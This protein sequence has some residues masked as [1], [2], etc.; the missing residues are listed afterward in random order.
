MKTLN[1]LV[2][3]TLPG[4]A[5]SYTLA[6]T[7]CEIS[8]SATSDGAM[9]FQFC[10]GGSYCDTEDFEV[11]LPANPDTGAGMTTYI[12]VAPGYEP[13]TARFIKEIGTDGWCISTVTWE[14]GSNL[15]GEDGYFW[16]DTDSCVDGAY[17]TG[18]CKTE[19]KLFNLDGSSDYEYDVRIKA[20]DGTSS[21]AIQA[22]FCSAGVC[23]GTAGEEELVELKM[24]DVEGGWTDAS[25]PLP[26]N[27]VAMRLEE[28]DGNGTWCAEE[29]AFNGFPLAPASKVLSTG[30]Q[31]FW[32]IQ[33]GDQSDGPTPAPVEADDP[34]PSPVNGVTMT[35]DESGQGQNDGPTPSPLDGTAT[36]GEEPGDNKLLGASW[37]VAVAVI[38]SA[39]AGA[40]CVA[41]T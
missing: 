6:V 32:N 16:L 3:A 26:F 21:S 13:T 17:Q 40:A 34:T 31:T 39:V 41:L 20:C 7:T 25:F 15:L 10:L 2:F 9:A 5:R 29:F 18:P 22:Y 19:W 30:A 33:N 11:E 14:G 24:N 27:P 36:N 1:L 8:N 23:D 4:G 38:T 35:D 28:P 37:E 12:S